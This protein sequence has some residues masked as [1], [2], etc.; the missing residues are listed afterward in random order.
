MTDHSPG[1]P[2]TEERR[3]PPSDTWGFKSVWRGVVPPPNPKSRRSSLVST[4][5]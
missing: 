3:S 2:P 1:N 4:E 5:S